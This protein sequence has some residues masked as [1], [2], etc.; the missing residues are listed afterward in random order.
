ME[1]LD[2]LFNQARFLHFNFL[3]A[4]RFLSCGKKSV[5]LAPF[6]IDG[7]ESIILGDGVVLQ[8]NC[9]LY[10]N[11]IDET[12]SPVL[13]IGNRSTLDSIIISL[14]LIRSLLR[15]TF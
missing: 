3:Y 8:S 6:R 11:P 10:C 2:K 1:L 7:Y 13:T 4:P 15:K 12:R 14:Q 9:W 5:I